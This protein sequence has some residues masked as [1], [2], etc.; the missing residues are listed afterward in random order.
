MAA[1]IVLVLVAR[2]AIVEGDLAGQTAF[3]QQFQCPVDRRVSDAGVF[4]LNEPMKFVGG[5]MVAGFEEGTQDGVPLRGL[6]QADTLQMAMEDILG[7]ANH[8]ARNGGL[9]VD[10]LLEHG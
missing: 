5:E 2:D 10:A 3:G 7:L 9:I 8:L 1:A 4:L 6:L